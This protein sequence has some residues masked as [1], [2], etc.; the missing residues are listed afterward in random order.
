MARRI[1]MNIG[2]IVKFNDLATYEAA[3][4]C[5]DKGITGR[6]VREEAGLFAIDVGFSYE[7]FA[8]PDQL[9]LVTTSDKIPHPID[10]GN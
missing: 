4:F 6:I 7:V 1:S 5:R 2:D 3:T 10:V 9:V 8:K